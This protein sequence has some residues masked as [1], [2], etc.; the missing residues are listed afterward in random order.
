MVEPVSHNNERQVCCYRYRE[1][2][3]AVTKGT[4]DSSC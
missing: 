4:S 1:G 2:S 3:E